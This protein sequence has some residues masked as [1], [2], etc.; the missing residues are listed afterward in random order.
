MMRPAGEALAQVVVGVPFQ[1]QRDSLG[2]EGAKTLPRRAP[3]VQ[4]DGVIGQPVG[5]IAPRDFA[6]QHRGHRPVHI[7]DGKVK[8][9]RCA[10]LDGLPRPVDQ[11]V[12]EG[13]VQA[14]ILLGDGA[15]CHALRHRRVE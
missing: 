1:G 14:V 11:A 3:E 4:A 7:A 5:T 6:A 10:P 15:A 8:L 13:L 9:D 12:I 2:K